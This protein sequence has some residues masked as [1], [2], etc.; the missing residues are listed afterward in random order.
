MVFYGQ[1]SRVWYTKGKKK[2]RTSI[3]KTI[4]FI[5]PIGG[6]EMIYL[7]SNLTSITQSYTT[8]KL[9]PCYWTYI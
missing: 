1:N 8:S 9:P 7:Q 2:L 3:S 5:H 4:K 6:F